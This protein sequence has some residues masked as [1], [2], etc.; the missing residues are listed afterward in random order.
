MKKIYFRFLLGIL[1]WN[2]SVQQTMT[3][4]E[5]QIGSTLYDLQTLRTMQNRI[6][7]F[8]D[9]SIGA[10]WNMRFLSCLQ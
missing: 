8:N 1:I 10:V 2:L 7:R 3:Q 5:T 4:E 9:G 6:F